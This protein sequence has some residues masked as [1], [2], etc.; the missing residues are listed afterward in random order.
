M[1]LR[2]QKPDQ[3]EAINYLL[4]HNNGNGSLL[5]H[6]LTNGCNANSNTNSYTLL[7][8]NHPDE[9]GVEPF[10]EAKTNPL[11]NNTLHTADDGV[12]AGSGSGVG[13]ELAGVECKRVGSDIKMFYTTTKAGKMHNNDKTWL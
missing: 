2:E 9:Y 8:S 13:S 3:H 6:P 1:A 7:Y 11:H 4:N 10:S 12:D 5:Y